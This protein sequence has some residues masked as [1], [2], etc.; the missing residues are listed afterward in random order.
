M[1]GGWIGGGGSGDS[2]SGDRQPVHEQEDFVSDLP[3]TAL[4]NGSGPI[5]RDRTNGT[6]EPDD[7]DPIV[8]AGVT[9]ERG[10]GVATPSAVRLYPKPGCLRFAAV[11]GLD[12]ASDTGSATFQVVVDDAVLA[13]I[14]PLD[15]GQTSD[16]AVEI[17]GDPP[18]PDRGGPSGIRH[19]R[20]G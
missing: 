4:R 18:G 5:E 11:V 17:I 16:V 19:G 2:G 14:G 15:A 12:P 9:Y 20:L 10:L 3:Y 7:G 6:A 13:T 8:V 1:S